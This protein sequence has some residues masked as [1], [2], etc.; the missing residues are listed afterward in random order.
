MM[1]KIPEFL[2]C[3]LFYR[4]VSELK[5]ASLHFWLEITASNA[6]SLPLVS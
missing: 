4:L 2:L 3:F 6:E 1:N 5:N